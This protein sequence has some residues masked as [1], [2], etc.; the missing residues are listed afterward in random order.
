MVDRSKTRAALPRILIAN[1]MPAALAARD[2]PIVHNLDVLK[3]RQM[4][5]DLAAM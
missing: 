3:I 2:L 1:R 4:S 5:A